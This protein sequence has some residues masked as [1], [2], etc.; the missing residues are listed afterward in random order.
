MNWKYIIALWF[1]GIALGASS[2]FGLTHDSEPYFWILIALIVP[3]V[4]AKNT[5]QKIFFHGLLAG[6]GI[7]IVYAAIQSTFFNMYL[8]THPEIILQFQQQSFLS[9]RAFLIV[10]GPFIGIIYGAVLGGLSTAARKF[11]T[12]Q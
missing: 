7:C 8:S 10:V 2:I 9:P 3:V 6:L 12:P 4:I 5:S 1:L 11:F